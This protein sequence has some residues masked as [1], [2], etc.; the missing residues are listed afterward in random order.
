MALVSGEAKLLEAV[1]EHD[2]RQPALIDARTGEALN[3]GQL[4]SMVDAA[5]EQIRS[6]GRRL[7]FLF[8]SNTPGS[9]VAYLG[10]LDADVPVYCSRARALRFR[11]GLSRRTSPTS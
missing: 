3:Y 4:F 8:C 5:A 2:V 9:I 10:C 6:G 1:R 11:S 7:H